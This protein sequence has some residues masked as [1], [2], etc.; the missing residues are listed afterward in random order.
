MNTNTGNAYTALSFTN[1]QKTNGGPRMQ[2]AKAVH[3]KAQ[4][5]HT[6][7]RASVQKPTLY[8]RE[9]IVEDAKSAIVQ[10]TAHAP[11][12]NHA[13][14]ARANSIS[15][16]QLIRRFSSTSSRPLV[17]ATSQVIA[18]KPVPADI[19]AP[20]NAPAFKPHHTV[21]PA[22]EDDDIFVAAIHAANSHNEPAHRANRHGKLAK[23]LKPTKGRLAVGSLIGISAIVA[24]FFAWQN[25]SSVSFRL[26]A[27]KAGIHATLPRIKPSG[28]A[29]SGPI[30]FSEGQV[31]VG[32]QSNSDDRAFEITQSSSAWD[33]QALLQNFVASSAKEYRAVQNNGRTIY[34]YDQDGATWVD[35]GV[36]YRVEGHSQLTS[37][38]LLS[39]ASSM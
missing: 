27:S 37:D 6:L 9:R 22:H 29:M 32:F 8:R 25:S 17:V 4:R 34:L 38:Q 1:P 26:A 33:S 39:L 18:V 23:R 11:Q 15:Q 24:G 13:R 20:I 7:M 12:T 14:A 10:V 35:G 5:P 21:H 3:Q 16:S 2:Y 28:F 36:W 30:R 31:T 19:T